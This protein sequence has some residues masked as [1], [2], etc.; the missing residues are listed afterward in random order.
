LIQGEVLSQRII[1]Y[2]KIGKVL[3][4]GEA[5]LPLWHNFIDMTYEVDFT[6]DGRE[7]IF[8]IYGVFLPEPHMDPVRYGKPFA[9]TFRV[10]LEDLIK[11]SERV[12]L[13]TPKHWL[14]SEY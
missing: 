3:A 14:F 13:A 2:R 12:R 1:P 9:F 6:L 10:K 11:E 8:N 4:G 7:A 5:P